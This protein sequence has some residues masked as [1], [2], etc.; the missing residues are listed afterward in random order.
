MA[1]II[2]NPNAGHRDRLR[3][4]F[5]ENGLNSLAEH[6]VLELILTFSIP[7]K[8]VKLIAKD[9]L[10]RYKT[11]AGVLDAE[12]LDIKKTFG[13]GKMTTTFFKLIRSISDKTLHDQ[14]RNKKRDAVLNNSKQVKEYLISKIGHKPREEFYVLYMDNQNRLIF[15]EPQQIGTINQTAV[16]PREIF[17]KALL[18]KAS[19]L[20][21]AH[22]H[23]S[24][25]LKPSPEDIRLHQKLA[26]AARIF[27]MSILDNMIVSSEGHFSFHE[28]GIL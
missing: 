1:E 20:I 22:N 24:G 14:F 8:D 9:L 15:D 21:F 18:H 26:E 11:L 27:Q 5:L 13:I 16:Y 12:P 17:E 3:L 23:P 10:G 25:T 7:R 28:A 2:K 4:R 19:S 6:E